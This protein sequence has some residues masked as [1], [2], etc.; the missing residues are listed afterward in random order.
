MTTDDITQNGDSCMWK[1]VS[2]HLVS[3][4]R[5]SHARARRFPRGESDD[6]HGSLG[7]AICKRAFLSLS[8]AALLVTACQE[9][10]TPLWPPNAQRTDVTP[11]DW[12]VGCFALDPMTDRLRHSGS[13]ESIELTQRRTDVVDGK[14]RY[15]AR[16]TGGKLKQARWMPL[17]ATTARLDV[18][19]PGS[20]SLVFKL[21]QSSAGLVGTYGEMGDVASSF[22]SD[23]PVSLHRVDCVSVPAK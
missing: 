4:K 22:T 2:W 17:T 10:E 5:P 13:P 1:P 19:S 16:V 12:M 15:Y 8:V 7:V 9:R 11:A 6:E 18:W 23:I 20:G 3:A 14:Q 21:S